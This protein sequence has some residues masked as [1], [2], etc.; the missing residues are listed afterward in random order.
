MT[1]NNGD[2][3]F[4]LV[5]MALVN[6]M[7]PGLAFF[8]GGLVRSSSVLT[9]MMQNYT[10]MGLIAMIWVIWGYSLSFGKSCGGV[11]G[12]PGTFFFLENAVNAES[13]FEAGIPTLAHAGFEGMFAVIAPSLMTGAFADRVRFVPYLIFIVVWVHLVYFPV[14]HALWTPEGWMAQNGVQDFAGGIV[15]HITAGFS[16]LATVVALPSRTKH[17]GEDIDTDPHNVPFVALGTGLLWFGW[18]GFNA[19][20]AYVAGQEAALAAMNSEISAS[21]AL[22]CWVLL[23]WKHEGKPTLVGACVGA[24]AGLATITPCAPYVEPWAAL[25]IGILCVPWCYACI[26]ITKKYDLDDALDVWAVH[27][28]GG[29]F[30]ILCVGVFSSK[31]A[32][33]SF[34]A[35]GDL[36]GTQ[37]LAAVGV[38]VYSFAIGYATIKGLEKIMQVVPDQNDLKIGLD[39]IMHGGKAYA[40][41]SSRP[42]KGDSHHLNT[43]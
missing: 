19:G 40:E 14:C 35:S 42:P 24:I 38:A 28:M 16:A 3:A 41:G 2:T 11:I 6:L 15:V 8:Y 29:F 43:T 25:L 36:F 31:T 10:S 26:E 30:G 27:G 37:L 21:A 17:E 12:S 4:V 34:E 9:I 33:G 7:T 32:T 39:L 18:F 22:C 1:I 13:E 23:E 5:S 20:S